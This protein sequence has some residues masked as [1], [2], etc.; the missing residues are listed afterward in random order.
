MTKKSFILFICLF[1]AIFLNSLD[2]G[3]VKKAFLFNIPSILLEVKE[4]QGGCGFKAGPGNWFVRGMV[5][6]M[7]EDDGE[8]PSVFLFGLGIAYE[9]HFSPQKFSPYCGG[10][11]GITYTTSRTDIAGGDWSREEV[12]IFEFGP[13]LGIE[14][15]LIDNISLFAE[16]QCL[17]R[18]GWPSVTT[19]TGDEKERISGEMQWLVDMTLGNAGMVGLCIYF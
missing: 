2:F 19:F 16:Y 14:V 15:Q 4:Y 1:Q 10:A 9:M 7:I 11:A 3:P 13:L 6:I 12:L 17:V 8:P 5:D 18:L